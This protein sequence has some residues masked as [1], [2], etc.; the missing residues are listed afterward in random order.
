M[1]HNDL[2]SIM[3]SFLQHCKILIKYAS[4]TNENYE[5][6]IFYSKLIGTC[7]IINQK[8]NTRDDNMKYMISVCKNLPLKLY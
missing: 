7:F 4:L 6:R 8:P 2:Q 3:K 5:K 1:L